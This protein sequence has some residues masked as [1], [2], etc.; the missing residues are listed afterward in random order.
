MSVTPPCNA[1]ECKINIGHS[2]AF[3]IKASS[4]KCLIHATQPPTKNESASE[5]Q[6]ARSLTL[7]APQIYIDSALINLIS[8]TVVEG[9]FNLIII[10]ASTEETNNTGKELKSERHKFLCNNCIEKE[11]RIFCHYT[12]K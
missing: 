6:I 9:E 1:A 4:Y 3:L 8:N 2:G 10:I 12:R 11:K 7:S 5:E